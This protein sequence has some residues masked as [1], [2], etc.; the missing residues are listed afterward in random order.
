[1]ASTNAFL[2][3]YSTVQTNLVG[4]TIATGY[5][6][7]VSTAGRQAYTNTLSS[8]TVA[9]LTA[10]SSITG[11]V[12]CSTM[13]TSTISG[14]M[15][16]PTVQSF[17]SGSGTYTP[18]AG[19]VRIKVRMCGPGGGGS[20]AT[21]SGVSG[22]AGGGGTNTTFGTG[23]GVQWA[24]GYGNGGAVGSYGGW[25]APVGASG[26]GT[27]TLIM[28]VKGG[29][30]QSGTNAPYASG[31]NGGSN[32]FG[33]GGGGGLW[34]DSGAGIA[35]NASPNTGGGGGGSGARSSG[36]YGG[37][38]GGAGEYVEFYMNNPPTSIAYVVPAGGN[39][40]TGVNP[41]ANGAAGVIIIEEFYI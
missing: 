8:L 16:A 31:G 15:K 14:A 5:I 20:S 6:P 21:G 30:G 34:T 4:S 28:R 38:G 27:G 10:V 26:N 17:L 37:S 41:G 25:C 19:T 7:Y 3:L 36:S 29:V 18:T 33:G 1:M 13:V 40:G 2:T 23:A 32:P 12:N 39:G 9:T 11:N 35:D 22:Q 24:A